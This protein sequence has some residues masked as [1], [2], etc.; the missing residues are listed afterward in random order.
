MRDITKERINKIL[1]TEANILLTTG[2][3]DDLCLKY[4]VEAGAMAVQRCKR[5]DLKRK[6]L[7]RAFLGRQRLSLRPGSVMMNFFSF[8]Y[9]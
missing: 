6:A 3:I 7:S 8:R 5:Q 4:F 9:I 2:G 1:A